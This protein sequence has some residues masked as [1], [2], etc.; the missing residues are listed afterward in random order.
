MTDQEDN[1]S[2]GVGD[3]IYWSATTI[4]ALLVLWVIWAY[5]YNANRGEPIIQILPLVI[6]AVVWV[7][8]RTCRALLRR[9][10]DSN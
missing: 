9:P 7:A 6:A 2:I 3:F 10:P 5:V 4:A 1:G 8:G